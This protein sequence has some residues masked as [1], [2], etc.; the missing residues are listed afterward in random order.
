MRETQFESVAKLFAISFAEEA[1]GWYT[2][3]GTLGQLEG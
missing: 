1:V 3:Y 2:L